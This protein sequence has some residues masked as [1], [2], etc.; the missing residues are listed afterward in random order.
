MSER[1]ERLRESDLD[2]EGRDLYRQ[3]VEGPRASIASL[4]LRDAAGSLHGPFGLML[5]VPRLGSPLQELGAAIRFRTSLA[6]RERELLTLRVASA[7]DS[8]FEWHAHEPAGRAAGLTD[9]DL[10]ALRTGSYLPQGP[11]EHQLLRLCDVLLAH[12]EL[13]DTQYAELADVVGAQQALEV[14]VLVGYYRTLAQ[15]MR[16]FGVGAPTASGSTDATD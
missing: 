7:L 6:D 2:A 4:Q 12:G 8:E 10:A 14:A 13:S 3:I 11:V 16:L 15:M 9:D 1:L 5:R